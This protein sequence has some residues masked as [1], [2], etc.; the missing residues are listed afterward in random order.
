MKKKL[1]CVALTSFVVLF[2]LCA[3]PVQ[4]YTASQIIDS[5]LDDM[6]NVNDYS[7]SLDC[8]IDLTYVD[9]MTDGSIQ[10]KRSG[11]TKKTNLISGAPYEQIVKSD[12][13]GWN[14]IYPSSEE[15]AYYTNAVYKNILHGNY[16]H[17][18]FFMEDILSDEVWS[19]DQNTATINGIDCY[20]LYTA[21]DD[22]N[23]EVWIDS[24][25]RTMVIRTKCTDNNDNLMFQF[26][27]TDYSN[28]ENTAYLP[29]TIV[30]KR[31]YSDSLYSICNY[32]LSDI[33]INESISDSIF[34]IFTPN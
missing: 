32:T 21:K 26:D 2:S 28:V 10:W 19:L 12:G 16:G 15:T 8:E 33:D 3:S 30:V 18:M 6:N 9:D 1:L 11:T 31:Y 29:A 17:D 13:T 7:A 34:T 23:Y 24:N 5:V 22:N 25:S 14:E 20:R 27:Y 4:A